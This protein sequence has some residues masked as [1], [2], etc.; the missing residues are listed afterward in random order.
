[1]QLVWHSVEFDGALG[2]LVITSLGIGTVV[3]VGEVELLPDGGATVDV[4][5]FVAVVSSGVD[6]VGS[7]VGHEVVEFTVIVVE[8]G[9]GV[10]VVIP[11]VEFGSIVLSVGGCVVS[12]VEFPWVVASDGSEVVIVV[13]SDVAAVAVVASSGGADVGAIVVSPLLVVP[14]DG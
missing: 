2:L 4:T 8:D 7:I 11:V 5:L 14:S 1:M 12:G 3:F 10:V 13:P 6:E 9:K